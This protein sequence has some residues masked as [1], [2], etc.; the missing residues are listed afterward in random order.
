MSSSH[1][2]PDVSAVEFDTLSVSAAYLVSLLG[3]AEQWGLSRTA[4]LEE[5]PLDAGLLQDKDHRIPARFLVGLLRAIETASGRE[6][7][8]L[9]MAQQ[10]RPGT[11][12]ALGYAAMSCATLGEAAALIP[13]YEDVVLDVGTTTLEVQGEEATLAW[14]AKHPAAHIRALQDAIVAGW[15][16]FA[17]WVTGLSG[18]YPTRVMFTHATPQDL[19]PYQQLFCCELQFSALRNAIVFDANFLRIPIVQADHA[20]N[21]MMRSKADAL[22]AQLAQSGSIRQRVVTWLQNV[23]PRQQATLACA[24]QA[25]G[26][27]ERT[28]RRRLAEEHSSFQQILTEV[29]VRLASLY[30]KDPTLTLLDIALLLGYADQSSFTNAFRGW[31]G[32]TPGHWR[33]E[34]HR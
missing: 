9:V 11:F 2:V 5:L 6:D 12:S 22:M 33:D 25:L 34:L 29:R 17:R 31:H 28:L 13:I 18:F 1:P 8:G 32:M 7:I 24:A 16:C 14:Q 4:L 26:F 27:S 23:L 20:F 3:T 19:S 15:F 10:A 21:R 30:L